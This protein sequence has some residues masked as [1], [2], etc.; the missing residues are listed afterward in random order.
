GTAFV[1]DTNGQVVKSK[2]D[3]K[4]LREVAEATGGIYLPL[5][6]GLRT[7]RSLF[8]DGLSKLSPKEMDVRLS[9]R[10]IE[11]YEWP[12]AAAVVALSA[13][14]LLRERKRVR[15]RHFG[16][17][18]VKLATATAAILILLLVRASASVPGLDL[19]RDGKYNEAYRA[20]Q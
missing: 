4:R 13:S 7:M 12:L 1:K 14:I 20:F 2:L 17:T 5:Q 19:Y 9:R 16:Q 11:R 8:D 3:E 18:P 10:P 6:T 15:V